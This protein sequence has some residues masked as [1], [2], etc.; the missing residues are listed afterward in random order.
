MK[1]LNELVNDHGH[2][3][4]DRVIDL[5]W[6]NEWSQE[7]MDLFSK[8]L[9]FL[10]INTYTSISESYYQTKLFNVE[11]DDDEKYT[12]MYKIKY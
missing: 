4:R 5:G 7:D 2:Y 12:V 10:I 11:S 3:V 6:E 8:L 9:K 1:T